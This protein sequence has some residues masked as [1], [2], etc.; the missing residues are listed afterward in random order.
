M[1][2]VVISNPK[3]MIPPEMIIPILEAFSAFIEKYTASG[4]IVET[5]SYAGT[6]GGGALINAESLEEL[7]AIMAENP[8]AGFSAIEVHPVVDLQE[9]VQRGLQIAKARMEAMAQMGG[10]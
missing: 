7:D 8:T 3:H 5:W 6:T 1:K 9:S 10:G 4:H 2:F